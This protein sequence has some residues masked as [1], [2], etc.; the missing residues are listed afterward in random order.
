MMSVAPVIADPEGATRAGQGDRKSTRLNSSHGSISYGVFC[1]KKNNQPILLLDAP[2]R[3][4]WTVFY[5]HGAAI[6]ICNKSTLSLTDADAGTFMILSV[7]FFF[8]EPA[9]PEFYPFS[10]PQSFPI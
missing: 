4:F 3:A 6:S 9:P 1:L 5:A 2:I 7:Y 8:N 10:P